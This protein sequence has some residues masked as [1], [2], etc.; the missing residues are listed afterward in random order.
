MKVLTCCVW[1]EGVQP[2]DDSCPVLNEPGV[3][4]WKVPDGY[5]MAPP[6]AAGIGHRRR[7]RVVWRF[8]QQRLQKR[9]LAE[10]V[11]SDEH[12][13]FAPVHD[14]P[15]TRH[16]RRTIVRLRDTAAFQHETA[17]RSTHLKTNEG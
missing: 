8:A 10:S 14:C 5:F 12:N 6:D 13:L 9:G 11:P 2:V 17:G 4:L 7:K 3:V 16:D 15:E 1:I